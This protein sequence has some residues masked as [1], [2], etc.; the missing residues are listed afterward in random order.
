V[1]RRK[2]RRAVTDSES[3]VRYDPVAKPGVANLLSIL[4]AA[5]DDKPEAL[6]G[7]YS[8]YGPLK[9]D[10]AE[11]VVELLRPLQQRFAEL[12]ADPAETTRILATGA[13]KARA[14]AGPTITRARERLGLPLL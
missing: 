5:T 7:N 14:M 2:F 1:I 4:A 8:Q 13:A 3:E 9:D 11:A 10:A 12:A 6:A